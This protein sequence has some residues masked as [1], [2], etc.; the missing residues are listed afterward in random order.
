MELF[1]NDNLINK[2]AIDDLTEEELD[3]LMII[4]S[5]AGY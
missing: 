4:L 3:Q 5:E 1:S 2:K